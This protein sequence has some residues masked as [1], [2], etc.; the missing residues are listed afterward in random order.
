M[1]IYLFFWI[2]L[3]VIF[4][5]YF[6][7]VL[8]LLVY[9]IFKKKSALLK[10][11]VE[12]FPSLTLI[13]AA[14]NEKEFIS[15]KIENTRKLIYP[16][17]KLKVLWVTDGSDDD[18]QDFI[19]SMGENVIHQK[20]RKGKLAAIKRAMKNT[21]SELAVFCDA[22]TFLNPEALQKLASVFADS[23][24][25][26][27]A[28][29][30]RIISSKNDDASGSGENIYWH[31]ESFIKKLE[32]SSGSTVGAAGELFAVRSTLFEEVDDNIILDDFVISL[33]IVKKGY[34]IAYVPEAYSYEAASAGISEELKRKTRIATGA[35]Q[36]IKLQPW[37]LNPTKKFEIFF[38]FFSHKFLRW[39]L[40]PFCFII[41]FISNLLI[42]FINKDAGVL[43]F[44]LFCLQ[45]IFYF[46]C[47]L[48]K[49]TEKRKIRLKIF[50]IPYY[51]TFMNYAVILG[52]INF[53]KGNYSGV[54][55]KAE[56]SK[57]TV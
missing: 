51:L 6:G 8:I 27:A 24:V 15:Q 26:C 37:L 30:K 38:K 35:M 9:S 20:E 4:Y 29:E 44:V 23:T 48:G 36:V 42:I 55:E 10:N 16:K 52:I 39:T 13:I 17:D 11:D 49:L 56:R 14:Y 47:F 57:T 45:L 1:I 32:S 28:G 25:G 5:I 7:Y 43:Y 41:A 21:D 34:R 31:Y 12:Y 53:F 19:R 46:F 3:I 40:L 22:N 50:F 18:S 2:S 33:N 54:W